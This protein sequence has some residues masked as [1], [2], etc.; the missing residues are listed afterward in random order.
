VNSLFD[1]GFGLQVFFQSQHTA[2]P[3]DAGLFE[4]AEGSEWIMVQCIDQNPT[5]IYLCGNFPGSLQIGRTNISQQ[6][7]YRVIGN[8]NGFGFGLVRH[9]GKD[10]AKYFFFG[11]AHI[12]GNAGKGGRLNEVAKLRRMVLF[13]NR[14]VPQRATRPEAMKNQKNAVAISGQKKFVTSTIPIDAIILSLL[15]LK[16]INTGMDEIQNVWL[17]TLLL[18]FIAGYCDTAT[19]VAADRI[20]RPR[21]RKFYRL[22]LP[23]DQSYG[24]IFLGQADH[25]A[26]IHSFSGSRRLDSQQE[27][28]QVPAPPDGRGVA[29]AKWAGR[30]PLPNVHPLRM[31]D[32]NRGYVRRLLNGAAKCV[33]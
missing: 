16:L 27:F 25:V 10:R 11:D 23:A 28:R 19:F 7:I 17:I 15:S 8:F 26:H 20:L 29:D 14:S 13:Q 5:R 12:P 32:V 30:A 31:D 4:S 9:D 18:S 2:F 24:R 6:S 3:S 21:D 33:R 1:D 22:C